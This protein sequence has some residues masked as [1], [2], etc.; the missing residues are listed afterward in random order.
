MAIVYLESI[1]FSTQFMFSLYQCVGVGVCC[2][3]QFNKMKG[4]R[5]RS[6]AFW[7]SGN[8]RNGSLVYSVL[9]YFPLVELNKYVTGYNPCITGQA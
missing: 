7:C 1:L 8:L 4:Q 6:V 2:D 3:S 5:E 9:V